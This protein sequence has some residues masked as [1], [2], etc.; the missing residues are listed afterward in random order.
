MLEK[1]EYRN[2]LDAKDLATWEYTCQMVR[3]AAVRAARR[4][5]TPMQ[6]Q[7]LVR[8]ACAEASY[9]IGERSAGE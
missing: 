4:G 2:N 6:F 7:E 3:E 1:R 8:R 9:G 5:M